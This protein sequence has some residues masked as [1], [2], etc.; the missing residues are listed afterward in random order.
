MAYLQREWSDNWKVVA[1]AARAG[2]AEEEKGKEPPKKKKGFMLLLEDEEEDKEEGNPLDEH[3][4]L[5][6]YLAQ[7]PVPMDCDVVAWWRVFRH[8]APN[9]AKMARQ[10]LATPA[11]SAGVERLFSAAG[12]THSDLAGRMK[13]T[14]LGNRLLAANNYG[15]DDYDEDSNA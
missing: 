8:Q 1:P 10:F 4:E 2:A 7:P 11:T 13:D 5:D 14:T 3:D 15:P 6:K 9:L 12:L